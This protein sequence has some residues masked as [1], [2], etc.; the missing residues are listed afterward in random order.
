MDLPNL[1]TLPLPALPVLSV[2]N[3]LLL[4]TGLYPQTENGLIKTISENLNNTKDKLLYDLQTP[5]NTLYSILSPENFRELASDVLLTSWTDR[6]ELLVNN[7]Y[8]SA[9]PIS[10]ALSR[11]HKNTNGIVESYL[12]LFS[13]MYRSNDLNITTSSSSSLIAQNMFNTPLPISYLR[14]YSSATSYK[15]ESRRSNPNRQPYESQK[16]ERKTGDEVGN[17]F[18]RFLKRTIRR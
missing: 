17:L 3:K 7:L 6:K 12:P 9:I 5:Y 1:R 11:V 14:E 4:D 2:V 8:S 13:T 18:Q 10:E 16:K 15:K